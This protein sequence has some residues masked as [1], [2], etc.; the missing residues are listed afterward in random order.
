MKKARKI[1]VIPDSYLN[2]RT[3]EAEN[4]IFDFL[5]KW[6]H[7]KCETYTTKTSGNFPQT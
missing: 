5:S 7:N 6:L 3:K 4:P 2:K 1:Y